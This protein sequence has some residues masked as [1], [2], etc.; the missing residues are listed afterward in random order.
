MLRI[1]TRRGGGMQ[2][3]LMREYTFD[4]AHHLE[5]HPGKCRS[6]H[7]HTYRIEVTVVGQLDERGVVMDFA[8]LD[9]VVDREVLDV[10]DHTLLNNLIPNPTAEHVAAEIY[11]R[12]RS[13]GTPVSEVRLWETPRSSVRVR[14]SVSP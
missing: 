14:P 12:L 8:E 3:E 5:W 11:A 10:Y 6:L 13:A 7:G 2:V 1:K 9:E 4:A